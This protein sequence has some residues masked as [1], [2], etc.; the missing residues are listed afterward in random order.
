MKIFVFIGLFFSLSACQGNLNYN[1]NTLN[2]GECEDDENC[3]GGGGNG[4]SYEFTED[5][6]WNKTHFQTL[7][8]KAVVASD[9]VYEDGASV[10]IGETEYPVSSYSIGAAGYTALANSENY[11]GG[12]AYG[13][14]ELEFS[15]ISSSYETYAYQE[16]TL[17][18]F[19]YFSYTNP[20]SF[21]DGAAQKTV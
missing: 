13:L 12:L 7:S 15:L 19:N 5:L 21:A 16:I 3:V 10:Y 9:S 1:F 8:L 6:Q 2:S 20:T 4:P 11:E 18:D 17:K 14:N